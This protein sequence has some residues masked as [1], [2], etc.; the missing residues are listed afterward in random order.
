MESHWF[1]ARHGDVVGPMALGEVAAMVEADPDGD[2]L[3]W[4]DGFS[5]WCRPADVPAL[6][7]IGAPGSGAHAAGEHHES[8]ADRAR[9]ELAAYAVIVAYLYVCF[10]ALLLYKSAVLSHAGVSFVPL[11]IAAIKALV[12]GKFLLLLHSAR[13]GERMGRGSRP[14]VAIA[15]QALLFATLLVLLTV[16]EELVVGTIHGKSVGMIM[17][18]LADGSLMEAAVTSLLMVLVLTPYFA[19]REINSELGDGVLFRMLLTPRKAR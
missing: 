7:T 6:R 2:L 13:V 18:E 8:L 9:H 3:V 11:G 19:L 17:S 14:I 4:A 5:A 16:I 10:G 12:L 1:V 15:R